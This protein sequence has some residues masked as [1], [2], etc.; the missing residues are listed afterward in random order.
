M[1]VLNGKRLGICIARLA[2]VLIPT[3]L[4]S[5]I[6]STHFTQTTFLSSSIETMKPNTP[7]SETGYDWKSFILNAVKN[8][9]PK[10]NSVLRKG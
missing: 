8:I 5:P 4:T 3:V 10:S 9:H 6:G 7:V 1:A 2:E